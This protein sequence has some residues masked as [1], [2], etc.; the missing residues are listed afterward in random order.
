L[1]PSNWL[2]EAIDPLMLAVAARRQITPLEA[3]EASIAALRE[4]LHTLRKIGK[5]TG[6]RD[7]RW[8][9]IAPILLENKEAVRSWLQSADPFGFAA[10]AEAERGQTTSE[11]YRLRAAVQ[12]A[13]DGTL[14]LGRPPADLAKVLAT[15]ALAGPGT[16]ALRALKRALPKG[17]N[18]QPELMRAAFRIARGFQSMFNQPEAALAVPFGMPIRTPYWRQVLSYLLAGNVQALLDEQCHMEADGLSLLNSNPA[19]TFDKIA[20]TIAAT[21]RLRYARIEIAGLGRRRRKAGNLGEPKGTRFALRG[22]HAVRFAE[23]R[24]EDGS[25]TRLDAVR[26]AFNSPFRPFLLASTSVGQEGLD[27]HPWCHVVC[28]WNLPRA[29]VELEQREGRVHRYKGHAV[30][31]NVAKATGLAT[32]GES[33]LGRWEDPWSKMFQIAEQVDGGEL[34]PCWVFDRCHSPEHIERLVLLPSL[35]REAEAWPLL[36]RRL[37]LYRLVLGQPRQEDLLAAL[38]RGDITEEQTRKWRIDLSPPR[39]QDLELSG[40]DMRTEATGIV[41]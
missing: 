12:G 22:R 15:A 5:R 13:I 18:Q 23:I 34:A 10:E 11:E 38:E 33:N 40:E 32:L 28:H 17:A 27:F 1:Y 31:L 29:P 30:R 3:Q 36:R 16:C 9:W 14:R 21:M 7:D 6:R 24:E 2:A 37:A 25:V 8:Y 41:A 39:A 26:E 35:S 20:D 19:D 4:P